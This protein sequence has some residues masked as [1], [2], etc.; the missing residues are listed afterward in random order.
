MAGILA[1]LL[2]INISG[3]FADGIIRIGMGVGA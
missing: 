1:Y 3:F 2:R